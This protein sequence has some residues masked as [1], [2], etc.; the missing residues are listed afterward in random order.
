MHGCGL[1]REMGF[2][3]MHQ[4]QWFFLQTNVSYEEK[5]VAIGCVFV[6]RR[7]K[8]VLASAGN[9]TNKHRN[10]TRH[11]ELIAYEKLSAR[12]GETRWNELSPF[13]DVF[14]SCEPCI[15]C[16]AALQTIG[17]QR[18]I[19]G[20]SN[21]RFGGCGSVVQVAYNDFG[22]RPFECYKGLCADEAVRIL[23]AFYDRGNEHAPEAKRKRPLQPSNI[24]AMGS[25]PEG[26][27]TLSHT[28]SLVSRSPTPTPSQSENGDTKW[29]TTST[30]T[31]DG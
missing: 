23:Q 7:T 10:A 1:K 28:S 19:Y 29:S 2:D 21:E 31:N 4:S 11:C 27:D 5:E 25:L 13:V 12:V 17:I 8:G 14:V 20:C 26:S 6:D 18:V 15:M 24:L 16:A 22:K 30:P 3:R 9:L